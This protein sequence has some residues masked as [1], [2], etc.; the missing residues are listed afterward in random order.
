MT[1][2]LEEH[3]MADGKKQRK[4]QLPDI[5]PIIPLR[6]AVL[7]PQQIMPLSIGRD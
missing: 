4:G 6:N 1:K 7:F 3:L 2:T 5:L